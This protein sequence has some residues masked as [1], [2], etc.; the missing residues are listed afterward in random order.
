MRAKNIS[1]NPQGHYDFSKPA[2]FKY[3]KDAYI[4]E[5]TNRSMDEYE[6][7]GFIDRKFLYEDNFETLV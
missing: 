4:K 5:A 1:P 6:V 3:F 2:Y 7:C